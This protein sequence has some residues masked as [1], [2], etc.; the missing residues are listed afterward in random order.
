L[1]DKQRYSTLS[2]SNYAIIAQSRNHCTITQ[3]LRTIAALE[4]LLALQQLQLQSRNISSSTIEYAL[5]VP[6]ITRENIL[7]MFLVYRWRSTYALVCSLLQN[8]TPLSLSPSLIWA[9][10]SAAPSGQD[11]NEREKRGKIHGTTSAHSIAKLIYNCAIPQPLRNQATIAQS[12]N[13]ATHLLGITKPCSTINGQSCNLA[14]QKLC[15][16][17]TQILRNHATLQIAQSRNLCLFPANCYFRYQFAD[18]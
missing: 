14:T 12:C 5:V 2:N 1:A 6:W 7:L 8:V 18:C 4:N 9:P 11:M 13:L 17:A 16:F 15:N 10:N 3:P